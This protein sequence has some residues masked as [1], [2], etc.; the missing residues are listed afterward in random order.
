YDTGKKS[1]AFTTFN[2]V[3]KQQ[4]KYDLKGKIL[5]IP[6]YGKGDSIV[7]LKDVTMNHFMTFGEEKKQGKTYL[8]VINYVAE[9]SIKGANFDF[10]NLFDGN[11]LLS[12]N[13]LKVVNENWS[14]IIGEL[15]PGI[16]KSYA[17][18]FSAIAQSVVSKV[19]V[20][21]IFPS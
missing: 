5:V 17:Q 2:P 12:D 6:V 10:K 8:K 4:G 13:I 16:V 20:D 14:V 15:R 19:P 3:L 21:D 9:L 1:L 7:T 18:I 11:K